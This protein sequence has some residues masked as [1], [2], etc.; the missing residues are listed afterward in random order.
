MKNSIL[1]FLFL[2]IGQL[3]FCQIWIEDFDPPNAINPIAT[4]LQ[5]NDNG[6]SYYGIM[7]EFG[8][9]CG[10]EI[11]MTIS[12][13]YTFFT[14]QFLGARNTD[15]SGTCGPTDEEFAQWTAIDISS[16]AASSNKLYLCVDIAEAN[17]NPDNGWDLSLIHI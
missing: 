6:I 14:G 1:T 7:C 8:G 3:T 15:N 13:G 5:C 12:S 16:C 4:S 10:N 2:L 11:D 17:E 9:G